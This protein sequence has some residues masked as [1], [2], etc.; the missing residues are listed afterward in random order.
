MPVQFSSIGKKEDLGAAVFLGKMAD[1]LSSKRKQNFTQKR[2][3]SSILSEQK[4]NTSHFYL[5]DEFGFQKNYSLLL[6]YLFLQKI[7]NYSF[8]LF[9]FLDCGKQKACQ[10]GIIIE[11]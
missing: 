11:K 7:C 2:T 8:T 9:T 5:L 1:L 3:Y 6:K 4:E 10:L